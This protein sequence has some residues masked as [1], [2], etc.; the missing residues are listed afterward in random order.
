VLVIDY[1]PVQ[2]NPDFI[3]RKIRDELVEIVPGTH[4]GRILYK[5]K[6]GYDNIGYFA[7]KT[8]VS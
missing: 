8:P 4:L 3:I 2:S 1:E 7:L 5:T 6:S